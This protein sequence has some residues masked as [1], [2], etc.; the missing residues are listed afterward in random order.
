MPSRP[1]SEVTTEI[2]MYSYQQKRAGITS[3]LKYRSVS[4]VRGLFFPEIDPKCSRSDFLPTGAFS[5]PFR[6]I[7]CR[8]CASCSSAANCAESLMRRNAVRLER[9]ARDDVP[10]VDAACSEN[11]KITPRHV[12][13][14]P[15]GGR[16]MM[17]G[18]TS[19]TRTPRAQTP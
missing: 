1:A 7:N 6:Q 19:T 17:D 8:E 3:R 14:Y 13:Y 18:Q 10:L 9:Q 5:P 2:Q 15:A 16:L 11:D 4:S 12:G